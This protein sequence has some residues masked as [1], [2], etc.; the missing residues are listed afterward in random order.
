MSTKK[1]SKSELY[2]QCQKE[3][4]KKI[5]NKTLI[6]R[7]DFLCQLFKAKI[8]YYFWVGFYFPKDEHLETWS[9]KR[10]ISLFPD[11]LHRSV[12]KSS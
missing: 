2:E 12:R 6:E 11:I 9:L 8:P 4:T 5:G 1:T 3:I 7:M 10:S